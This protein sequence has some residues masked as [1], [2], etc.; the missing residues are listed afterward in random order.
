MGLDS[1]SSMVRLTHEITGVPIYHMDMRSMTLPDRFVEGIWCIA[2][3]LHLPRRDVSVA[4]REFHRILQ[5]GGHLYLSLKQ[6]TGS[7]LV[8]RE[9]TG[10]SPRLFTYFAQQ[11][12]AQLLRQAGFTSCE[13]MRVVTY[14]K[15]IGWDAWINVLVRKQ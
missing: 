3:L 6:G 9:K 15:S 14:R 5:Q 13:M 1:S 7:K 4:L 2:T 8:R 10:R 12:I 11:E